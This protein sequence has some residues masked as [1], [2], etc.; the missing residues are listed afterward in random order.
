MSSLASVA[1]NVV[2]QGSNLSKST[3]LLSE[4]TGQQGKIQ[5]IK[6]G[7][8]VILEVE[9]CTNENHSREAT[10][11]TN[12]LESDGVVSDHII[13]NP[14]DLSITGVI[15]DTPLYDYQRFLAQ[16]YGNALSSVLPP[17][18]ITGAAVAYKS[19]A[20]QRKQDRPALAAY[21]VLSALLEAAEPFTLV[22][23]YNRYPNMVLK[24]LS[25]PRDAQTSSACTF[26]LGITQV[27]FVTPQYVQ[28][29]ALA[30]PNLGANLKEGGER[31]AE[32][33]AILDREAAGH[34]LGVD[35]GTAINNA[36]AKVGDVA[37]SG[38]EAIG[39]G[40]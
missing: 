19:A 24:S 5:I 3:G 9:V 27:H 8:G 25:L 20:A 12:P 29:S 23:S 1:Q 4:L 38:L 28:I 26:T 7:I 11:T 6:Q 15:S 31:S 10:V 13:K 34:T 33:Q 39:I 22:T 16:S 36:T 37:A 14:W 30:N 21:K 18:G 40:G 2:G 32:D 35:T 17:L